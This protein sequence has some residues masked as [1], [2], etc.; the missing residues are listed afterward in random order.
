MIPNFCLFF[1]EILELEILQ[2]F[3]AYLLQGY[4][5]GICP[6]TITVL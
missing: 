6:H 4:L 1:D 5:A 2:F 3:P